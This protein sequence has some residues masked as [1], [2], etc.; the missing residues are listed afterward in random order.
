MEGP[1]EP[2]DRLSSDLIWMAGG[3]DRLTLRSVALP[4]SWVVEGGGFFSPF[5]GGR[6]EALC[7]GGQLVGHSGHPGPAASRDDPPDQVADA[8]TG[9]P[10]DHGKDQC[11]GENQPP[12]LQAQGET[13][14]QSP[15]GRYS[16]EGSSNGVAVAFLHPQQGL[17]VHGLH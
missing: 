9:R 2:R 5:P 8:P 14:D 17:A 10:Q 12:D 6:K 7:L 3:T 16:V 1:Q 15:R 4:S 13:K 11:N